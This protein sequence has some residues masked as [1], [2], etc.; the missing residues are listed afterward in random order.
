[1]RDPVAKTNLGTLD[2]EIIC[3]L[4]ENG[5]MPVGAMAKISI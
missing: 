2:N 4:T 3:L 1:M 5:L